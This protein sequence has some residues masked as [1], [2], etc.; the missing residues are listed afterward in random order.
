MK[1]NK[2]NQ[3]RF[4]IILTASLL[5]AWELIA[6]MINMQHIVPSPL[7]VFAKIWEIRESL[8]LKHLPSTL[9]TIVVGLIISVILGVLLAIL[10]DANENIEAMLYPVM[11]VT[12]S[13]PTMCIAPL[14][15]IWFGYSMTARVIVVVLSAFFSITVN[16]FDGFKMV[17]REMDELMVTYGA[18][19]WKRFVALKIPTALPNF[20]SALKM[21]VPWAV[22]GS[23]VAEWLGATS[24]LGYFSKR[25]MSKMDGA[26]IFAP[27]VIL[28][29][30]AMFGMSLIKFTENRLV[31]WRDEV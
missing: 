20:F 9:I 17:K 25:M 18:S 23:A 5:I 7:D 15:V 13:I 10:M 1:E 22:I 4:N 16:T 3:V 21:A 28:S 27:V 2:K 26:A 6:L 29:V 30:L 12:Q 11:I 19:T 8:F 24:G 14:F 31:K